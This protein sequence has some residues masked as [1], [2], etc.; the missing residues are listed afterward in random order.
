MRV[1]LDTNVMISG[2]F[3]PKGAPRKIVEAWKHKKFKIVVSP[4][5]LEE[6]KDTLEDFAS[7]YSLAD[8]AEFFKLVVLNSE[9]C[10]AE[11]LPKKVCA[12]PD[13][14]KFIACAFVSK[15]KI[16]VSGDKHLLNVSG[17]RGINV[18]TP[19]QF[20]ETYPHIF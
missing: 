5:I 7:R 18:L 15:T 17:Y 10:Q 3:F 8:V 16:I 11:S 20:V 14:D 6:Y 9:Y 12:D 13:D 1:V 4:I 2:I 19:R